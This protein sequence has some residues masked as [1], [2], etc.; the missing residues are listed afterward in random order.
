M[1]VLRIFFFLYKFY[2]NGNL[3]PIPQQTI[4]EIRDRARIEDVVIRYVP[5]LK[6]R[7][8]NYVGLCPF[9]KEKTP[10]FTVSPDKQIFHCFGC[11]AGG[12][13]FTFISKIENVEFPES[14]KIVGKI[15]GVDVN[16]YFEKGENDKNQLLIKINEY[17]SKLYSAYLMSDNG[18]KAVDYLL[19]R[20]INNESIDKFKLGYAPDSWDFIK[21]HLSK[22]NISFDDALITG[23]ISCKKE[24]NRFYDRFRDRIMF[25]IENRYERVVAFGGRVLY[26]GEPK[27]LNSAETPVFKKGEILYG[28]N[29]AK[30][31]IRDCKRVIVVE[32]YLDVIGCSQVGIQNVVA[33]LGTALTASHLSFLS[34]YAEEIVLL[35]DS[36]DAGKKASIRS[37]SLAKGVNVNIKVASLNEGDPF[38]YA[39]QKGARPLMAIIDN[40]LNPI[41]YEIE[42]VLRNSKSESV[43]E[44]L[45]KVFDIIKEVEFEVERDYYLKKVASALNIDLNSVIK[46]FKK[47]TDIQLFPNKKNNGAPA[48]NRSISFGDR[49]Y[50]DL[51]ILLVNFTDLI[52]KAIMDF[53][54]NEIAD[55]LIKSIYCKII[56]VSDDENIE[57]SK[58]FDMFNVNETEFI[59]KYMSDTYSV[60]DEDAAYTEIYINHELYK[61]DN[62]INFYY[63]KINNDK[64]NSIEYLTEIEVLR[65]E[66]EKLRNYVY[67]VKQAANKQTV[68]GF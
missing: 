22:K 59:N 66:K 48:S 36:D 63:S 27:Y 28:F 68:F 24:T 61:I 26:D 67:N 31:A 16:D 13:V 42:Y 40:A 49:T 38:D 14:V 8:A 11:H 41:D 6:K 52:K 9:H 56:S 65:R 46:D 45:K 30:S 12:N 32:G 57:T 1:C 23:V 58:L 60:E 35:F 15:Y 54:E 5:S 29:Q 44:R 47:N 18:I 20:G 39:I 25:P 37:L 10:S 51:I 7:G 53:S 33:P 55:E 62:K 43:V 4:D 17:C 3:V 19:S 2:N 34:R 64:S 21:N 50:L